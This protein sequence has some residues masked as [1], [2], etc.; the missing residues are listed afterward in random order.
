[1]FLAKRKV[2]WQI[3]MQGGAGRIQ[4]DLDNEKIKRQAIAGKIFDVKETNVEQLIKDDTGSFSVRIRVEGSN[5]R[6]TNQSGEVLDDYTP[7][8]SVLHDLTGGMLGVRTNA[9]F[10]FTPGGGS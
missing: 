2:S 5:I 10:K 9:E 8:N 3:D 1:M 7:Q 4:Y 6:I